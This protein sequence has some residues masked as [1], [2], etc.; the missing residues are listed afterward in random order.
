MPSNDKTVF[1]VLID[2]QE[3]LFFSKIVSLFKI[4]KKKP[5][6]NTGTHTHAYINMYITILNMVGII[7][8]LTREVE[9]IIKTK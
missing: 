5:I 3:I 4:I 7:N 8:D 2:H 1:L 6:K 9:K